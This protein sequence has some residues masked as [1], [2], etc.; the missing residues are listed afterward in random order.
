[1]GVEKFA[2]RT[3]E[4]TDTPTK[5]ANQGK[6]GHE[7]RSV[8]SRWAESSPK[9]WAVLAI[10]EGRSPTFETVFL[11]GIKQKTFEWLLWQWSSLIQLNLEP[12]RLLG[13]VVCKVPTDL[14]KISGK[15]AR[16][17]GFYYSISWKILL[18]WMSQNALDDKLTLAQVMVCCRQPTSHYPRH[19][20]S[21]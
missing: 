21:K 4:L 14:V 18:M 16:H 6:A 2:F 12:T 5:S 15:E 10:V 9:Q 13:L 11:C 20:W 1:M 3:L 17:I 7:S 19:C 8:R